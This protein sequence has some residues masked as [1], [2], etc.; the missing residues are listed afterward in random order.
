[1]ARI[2][3]SNSTRWA[4][5]FE[6]TVHPGQI[7]SALRSRLEAGQACPPELYDEKH[8]IAAEGRLA[9][10]RVFADFDVILTPGALGEAPLGHGSTGNALFNR[11]WTLLYGPAVTVCAGRGRHGMPLGL[12]FIGLLNDDR[13]AL[14]VAQ[15]AETFFRR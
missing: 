13:R 5:A 11:V 3:R 2:T 15:W 6:L 4:L 8:R 1:M 9:L 12:Q 10:R 7:S 14:A